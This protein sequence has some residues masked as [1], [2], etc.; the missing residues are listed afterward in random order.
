M[1]NAIIV[2]IVIGAIVYLYLWWK[3]EEE[4][5]KDESKPKKSINYIIPCV[6]AVFGWFISSFYF[7]SVQTSQTLTDTHVE[8]V[9]TT[10]NALPIPVEPTTNLNLKDNTMSAGSESYKLIG[11]KQVTLPNQDVFIDLA[12]F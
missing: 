10:E 2:G 8:T 1:L 12:K 7:D 3:N 11:K 6:F 9:K 4:Y 5:K